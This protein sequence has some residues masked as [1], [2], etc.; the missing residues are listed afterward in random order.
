[1]PKK[2]LNIL[3]VPYSYDG[4]YDNYHV[5]GQLLSWH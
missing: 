4:Q 5:Y 2:V 3:L 1:M